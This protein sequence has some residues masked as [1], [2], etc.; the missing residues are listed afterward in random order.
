[1]SEKPTRRE[2]RLERSHAETV[3]PSP[4]QGEERCWVCGGETI[5]RHC[6]IVCIRCGFTRDC[7]D[8]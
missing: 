8:P 1:M 5:S 3:F 4:A 6:R 7:S 2:K